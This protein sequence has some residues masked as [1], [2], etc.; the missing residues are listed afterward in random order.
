ML[1][2]PGATL[3]SRVAAGLNEAI[4]LP[5]MNVESRKT[6]CDVA[7]ALRSATAK[8][9]LRSIRSHI[10]ES[11]GKDIFNSSKFSASLEAA[12]TA[13]YDLLPHYR[14]IILSR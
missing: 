1:T 12:Y 5:I 9:L 10:A 14:N 11:L 8:P 4:N 2:V 6:Y 13:A 7:V 3:S